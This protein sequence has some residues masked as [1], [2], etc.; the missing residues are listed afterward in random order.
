[1]NGGKKPERKREQQSGS[2]QEVDVAS[3]NV[4]LSWVDE[5][6]FAVEVTAENDEE[7]QSNFYFRRKMEQGETEISTRP[8][9]TRKVPERLGY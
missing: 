1:M 6:E 7:Y 2:D 9:R 4:E 8:Q 3:D 5:P